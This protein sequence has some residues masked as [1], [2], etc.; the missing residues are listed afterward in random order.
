MKGVLDDPLGLAEQFD[1]FLGPNIYT[2]EEMQSIIGILFS[3][4]ERQM[5]RVAGIKIWERENQQAPS[6]EQKMPIVTVSS[7]LFQSCPALGSMGSEAA[8]AR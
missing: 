8:W 7:T 4:E 2:W 3:L 5:I 1:Q 6:G